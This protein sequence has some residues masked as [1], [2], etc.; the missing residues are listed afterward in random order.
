MPDGAAR[1]GAL[2]AHCFTCHS[3]YRFIRPCRKLLAAQGIAVLRF[4]FTG[5]GRSGG[6]F[7]DSNFTT[8]I[9][10]VQAAAPAW[11]LRS[12]SRRNC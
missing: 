7:E 6:R 11:R 5:L 9:E 12:A 1:A 8:N 10:D 2:F 3:D 4:D